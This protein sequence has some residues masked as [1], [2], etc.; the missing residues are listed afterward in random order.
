MGQLQN[1]IITVLYDEGY[2]DAIKEK[3]DIIKAFK[4]EVRASLV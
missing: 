3:L 4:A 2:M 1:D